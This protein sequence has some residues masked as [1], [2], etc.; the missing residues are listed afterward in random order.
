MTSP[1]RAYLV[2]TSKGNRIIEASSAST[3]KNFV[4]SDEVEVKALT[5]GELIKHLEAGLKV[6]KLPA[7]VEK[8]AA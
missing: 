1:T 2:S 7:K 6:E 8:E 5:T 3:A 4:I